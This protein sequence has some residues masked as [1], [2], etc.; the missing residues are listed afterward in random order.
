MV[1]SSSFLILAYH[2]VKLNTKELSS[3]EQGIYH[4][5]HKDQSGPANT[6]TLFFTTVKIISLAISNGIAL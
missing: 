4:K 3:K 2:Q 6:D 5:T 1:A